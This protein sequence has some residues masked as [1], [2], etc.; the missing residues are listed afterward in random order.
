MKSD[1]LYK[2]SKPFLFS[3]LL[4][5]VAGFVIF[6]SA[7]LGLFTRPDTPYSFIVLKQIL[8]GGGLGIIA[9]ILAWKLDYKKLKNYSLYIFIGTIILNLLIFVPHLGFT[10]GGATR[11]ISFGPFTFQPSDFLRIGAVIFFAAWLSSVKDK[12]GTLKYGLLPLGI[13]IVLTQGTLLIQHD[14]DIVTLVTIMSMFFVAGGKIRHILITCAILGLGL[15]VLAYA[16][17]YVMDRF[18][19]FLHPSDNPQGSGYQLNQSLIAIG[20]GGFWGKGFGQ[21]IQKFG[22]LPEPI[23]DSVFAVEA[24]EFG[25]VGS[26]IL[27]FLFVFW[28][29]AGFKI[30]LKAKDSFGGLL[31]VGLVLAITSQAFINMGSMLGI[32]PL[33]GVPLPFISQGGTSLILTLFAC[34]IIMSIS[35]KIDTE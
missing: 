25:F 17:P 5:L 28:T 27:V 4:L 32:M 29:T 2:S 20:S 34:G 7:S 24:E 30:S 31:G 23:G 21:G 16:R 13:M 3:T 26:I 12:V 18:T 33:T 1:V 19:S 35:R 9:F 22:Y 10:H 11:W 6:L 8:G 15:V 14:T